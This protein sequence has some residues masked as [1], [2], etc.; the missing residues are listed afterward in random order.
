M[1]EYTRDQIEAGISGGDVD[2]INN[3]ASGNYL[4]LIHI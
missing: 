1:V 2:I 4:S 3:V